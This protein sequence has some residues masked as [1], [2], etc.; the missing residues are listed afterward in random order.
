MPEPQTSFPAEPVIWRALAIVGLLFTV[1]GM[2]QL[3]SIL[4]PLRLGSGEWEFGTYSAMMDNLPL[5]VMGLGFAIAAA[6]G[7]GRLGAAR[8]AGLLLLLLVLVMM[9]GAFLYAT[10]V[11]DALRTAPGTPFA[12]GIKKAVSKAAVQT[13][14]YPVGCIWLA[15]SG[16]RPDP[17]K[18]S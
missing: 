18:K 4:F 6:W 1:I 11:P 8:I 16:L 13:A 15:I 2:A 9:A 5:L 3:W 14:V 17:R 12:T 7:T 10:N